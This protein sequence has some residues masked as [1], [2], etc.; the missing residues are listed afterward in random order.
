MECIYS[1]L[2]R[3][4]L[5]CFSCMTRGSFQ[6]ASLVIRPLAP[7]MFLEGLCSLMLHELGLSLLS[8][9]F[10][11]DPCFLL[12]PFALKILSLDV[13]YLPSE[14]CHFLS[15]V[16]GLS[17]EVCCTDHFSRDF[18]S[19]LK[20]VTSSGSFWS[21]ISYSPLWHDG[22]IVLRVSLLFAHSS[23]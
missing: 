3:C 2:R 4:S 15:E 9:K 5:E 22:P 19:C 13:F 1:I 16:C 7:F 6:F 20:E 10:L 12:Y 21:T 18:D 23:H 8:S 11:H 17:C 14:V